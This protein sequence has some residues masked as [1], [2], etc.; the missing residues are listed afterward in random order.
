MI[1]KINDAVH[2]P[3]K[4]M[5]NNNKKKCNYNFF[6]MLLDIST[7]SVYILRHCFFFASMLYLKKINLLWVGNLTSVENL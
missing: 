5:M 2:P 4:K 6:Y 1:N 3:L 7:L